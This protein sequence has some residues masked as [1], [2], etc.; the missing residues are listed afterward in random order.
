M[1]R[2][3]DLE[4]TQGLGVVPTP[5]NPNPI[6]TI[7]RMP[8]VSPQAAGQFVQ[9][10]MVDVNAIQPQQ[11]PIEEEMAQINEAMNMKIPFE[12]I[13]ELASPAAR[14]VLE[15]SPMVQEAQ[16]FTYAPN[17]VQSRTTGL[18]K[19]QPRSDLAK[20][21]NAQVLQNQ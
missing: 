6:G 2:Y 21:A 15:R 10:P 3:S 4:P 7:G 20:W 18:G 1:P 13:Y 17:P 8:E 14:S 19:V 5:S 11:Q 16:G 12:T 9:A